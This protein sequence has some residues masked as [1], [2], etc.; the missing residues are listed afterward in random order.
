MLQRAL[1]GESL[2]VKIAAVERPKMHSS[3]V[4]A[5]A[6][7]DNARHRGNYGERSDDEDGP[8]SEGVRLVPRALFG[9]D[10]GQRGKHI[11]SGD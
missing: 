5:L 1:Y 7:E 9:D 2:Y 10:G 6:R 4:D 11:T 8:V 3:E